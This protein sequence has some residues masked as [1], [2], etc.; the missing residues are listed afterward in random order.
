M[1]PHHASSW[2]VNSYKD[3]SLYTSMYVFNSRPHHASSWLVDSYKDP[4]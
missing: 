4:A 1:R 2:L 3:P